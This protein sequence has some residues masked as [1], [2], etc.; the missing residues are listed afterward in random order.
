[1]NAYE[2]NKALFAVLFTC[3]GLLVLNLTASAIFTPPKP[4]KPGYQIAV[5]GGQPEQ[6]HGAPAGGAAEEP[7]GVLLASSSPE[8]G[9]SAAKVCQTCHTFEKGGANKVGPNL[10]GVVG[11]PKASEAGFNYSAAM[12]SKGGNWSLDELN[13]FLL[14]PRA[15]IPGTAMSFAGVSRGSQRADIINY[16]NTLADSPKPLPQA[17]K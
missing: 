15:D 8:R 5:L 16:L 6:G 2:I 13:A 9:Q 7:I 14:N 11:R 3:L 17:A 12:K 4:D 10:W 1:M